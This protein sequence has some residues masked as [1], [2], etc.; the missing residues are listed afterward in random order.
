[1]I[2]LLNI[3]AFFDGWYVREATGRDIVDYTKLCQHLG[4]VGDDISPSANQT[5]MLLVACSLV[6]KQNMR[7]INISNIEELL[8]QPLTDIK[9]A[10]AVWAEIN[11]GM[12]I[13][14]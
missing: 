3:S 12:F 2:E 5:E 8:S 13:T 1:M 14:I 4:L 11:E 7:R 9:K 10:Y 6:D